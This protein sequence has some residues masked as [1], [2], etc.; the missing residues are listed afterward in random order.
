M[1]NFFDT[2]PPIYTTSMNFH[3][4][5]FESS[6]SLSIEPGAFLETNGLFTWY[7]MT[8]FYIIL[9]LNKYSHAICRLYT[10]ILV[11]GNKKKKKRQRKKKFI[12]IC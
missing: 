8:H 1:L 2:S 10:N 4:W 6:Q 9:H 7:I 12:W 11:N 3:H 5:Y